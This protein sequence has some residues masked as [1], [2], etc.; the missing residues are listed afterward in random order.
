MFGIGS[1][2]TPVYTL[3]KTKASLARLREAIVQIRS[4]VAGETVEY[5]P[6]VQ[7]SLWSRRAVPIYLAAEGPR[8]L[9]LAAELADGVII[10]SGILP[11]TLAWA[12]VQLCAGAANRSRALAPLDQVH[13]AIV[14]VGR[15]GRAAREAARA[16]VANRAHHNFRASLESVPLERRP[17]VQRLLEGFSVAEWRSPKHAALVTDYLLDRFAVAG[18]PEACVDRLRALERHGVRRLMI[19]PPTVGFD[20]TLELFAR[21]VMPH[22]R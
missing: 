13:A 5:Q 6:A 16:R 12:E 8:T 22:C 14:A 11:E 20:E 15:D 18:T 7:V 19:D 17:E 3:G 1:G 4:L 21:E 2:D 10:G 9:G